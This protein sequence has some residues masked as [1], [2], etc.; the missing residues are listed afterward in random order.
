MKICFDS[1][2]IKKKQIADRK[3]LKHL[4]DKDDVTA[5]YFG[6]SQIFISVGLM[7]IVI[8]VVGY[9]V[10][11]DKLDEIK[12]NALNK[13]WNDVIVQPGRVSVTRDVVFSS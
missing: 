3:A 7:A 5:T 6:V 12:R 11:L 10:L 1:D 13:T 8:G 9:R 4:I 2:E